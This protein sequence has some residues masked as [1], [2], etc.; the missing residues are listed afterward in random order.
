MFHGSVIQPQIIGRCD[1]VLILYLP[2][3]IRPN[4][5]DLCQK[6]TYNYTALPRQKDSIDIFWQIELLPQEG[7]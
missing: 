6:Y 1:Q 2:W 3:A 7:Q 5:K 4:S